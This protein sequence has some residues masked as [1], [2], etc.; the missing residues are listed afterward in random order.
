[1][2]VVDHGDD[3]NSRNNLIINPYR[4]GIDQCAAVCRGSRSDSDSVHIVYL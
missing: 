4:F 1:M 2:A 3:S